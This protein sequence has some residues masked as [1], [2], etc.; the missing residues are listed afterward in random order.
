M[1]SFATW[2]ADN[3]LAG[4]LAGTFIFL[5][6]GTGFFAYVAWSDY[7]QATQG[8]EDAATKLTQL[9]KQTP[10]PNE[11]NLAKFKANLETEQKNLLALTKQMDAYRIRSTGNLDQTKPQDRPQVFQDA[12]RAQVTKIK[13]LAATKG[14]TLPLG[15][16]LGMEEFENQLPAPEKALQL[17]KQ[18]T[19]SS[20]LAENLSSHNGLLVVEFAGTQSASASK[21]EKDTAKKNLPTTPNITG[22]STLTDYET[23]GTIRTSFRCDQQTLNEVI[24]AISTAPCFFIIEGL[25]LQNTATE[26]PR[27]DAPDDAASTQP[28][29]GQDTQAAIKRLPIIVGRE[30]L[31]VSL[32]LRVLDFPATN[33]PAPTA[34]RKETSK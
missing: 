12:L 25:Q 28:P 10:F 29:P 26:P 31:I 30:Q 9:N 5:F 16:Y 14:A 24:T 20:W 23:L 21:K 32:R 34:K 18:L 13:S 6:L 1:N 22:N 2:F 27:R 17:S 33:D 19:A 11:S 15:F 8:Y 4:I 7:E 3:K